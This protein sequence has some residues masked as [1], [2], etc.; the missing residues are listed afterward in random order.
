MGFST[1]L[2]LY[3]QPLTVYVKRN[4]VRMIE[5]G[6]EIIPV[7]SPVE[8]V[9]RAIRDARRD[10]TC[11][12]IP[13]GGSTAPANAGFFFAVFELKKQMEEVGINFDAVFLPAGTCGT[14]TGV[15]VGWTNAE[16]EGKIYGVAVVERVITN[17]I[18]LLYQVHS[19]IK[20]LKDRGIKENVRR[21]MKRV[22][23]VRGYLGRGYG[24][25]TP[26]SVYA[27]NLIKDVEKLELETTY[28]GKALSALIDYAKERG[29]GNILFWNT[30]N[31][32]EYE[33]PDLEERFI[34]VVEERGLNYLLKDERA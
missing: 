4:L 33:I 23:I 20:F 9:L 1:T 10:K 32:Y 6:G 16:L 27:V 2:Y 3:P 14:L 19:L 24:D 17:E 21:V 7:K 13:P 15:A 25:P 8:S 22:K 11:F 5:E 31:A 34:K 28:T 26:D 12:F 18:N 30:H 29:K